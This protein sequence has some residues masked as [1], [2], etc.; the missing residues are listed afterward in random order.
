MSDHVRSCQIT[1]L[2]LATARRSLGALAAAAV[3]AREA[4]QHLVA[5]D[6]DGRHAGAGRILVAEGIGA[7]CAW[8]LVQKRVEGEGIRASCSHTYMCAWCQ[9]HGEVVQ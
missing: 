7:W 1:I 2:T 8:S 3:L 9:M 4:P 6:R 5:R